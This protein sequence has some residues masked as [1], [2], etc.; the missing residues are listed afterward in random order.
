MREQS[1]HLT[2]QLETQIAAVS[3]H[4]IPV[5]DTQMQSNQKN[6]CF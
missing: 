4:G 6:I 3:I 1:L 2:I 5:L